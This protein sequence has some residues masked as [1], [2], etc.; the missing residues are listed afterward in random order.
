MAK[1]IVEYRIHYGKDGDS[2]DVLIYE[3]KDWRKWK[4]HIGEEGVQWI[5]RVED[6]W[7]EYQCSVLDTEYE[8]LWESDECANAEKCES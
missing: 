8:I 4:Q 7:C 3:G 1:K 5:E 2:H 6:E